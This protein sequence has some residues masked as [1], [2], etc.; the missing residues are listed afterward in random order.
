[1]DVHERAMKDGTRPSE[2]PFRA[3]NAPA[4]RSIKWLVNWRLFFIACA[5]LF[6]Y[7]GGEE[8]AVSHYLFR[9]GA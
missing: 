9:K 3:K 8:W 6:G 5:E 2:R 1:M 4:R 7:R